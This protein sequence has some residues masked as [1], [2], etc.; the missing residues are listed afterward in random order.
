[1]ELENYINSLPEVR[2]TRILALQ[3]MILQ[4]APHAIIDMHYKMPSYHLGDLW[5]AMASQKFYISL[6]TCTRDNIQNFKDAYPK[7]RT[8]QGCINF[9]DK[10]ELPEKAI[11]EVVMRTLEATAPA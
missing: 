10:D 5:V 6:Y 3:R 2:R 9:K 1:M 8:G 7:I 11:K 4:V